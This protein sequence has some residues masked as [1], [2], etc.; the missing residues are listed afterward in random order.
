MMVVSCPL[1]QSIGSNQSHK[2]Q[3]PWPRRGRYIGEKVCEYDAFMFMTSHPIEL[4]DLQ[5]KEKASSPTHP[6]LHPPPQVTWE[7][8]TDDAHMSPI[9]CALGTC[10]KGPLSIS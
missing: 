1:I 7:V 6:R 2:T 5:A 3:D 10:L 9:M 8:Y 4:A